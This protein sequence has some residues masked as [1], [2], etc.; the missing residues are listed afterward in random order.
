MSPVVPSHK[1]K[2][3]NP[4]SKADIISPS[5]IRVVRKSNANPT[6]AEGNQAN[7]PRF[8]SKLSSNARDLESDLYE[9]ASNMQ[10][11]LVKNSEGQAEEPK[12]R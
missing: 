4:I 1:I 9:A 3:A 12:A 2:L 7:I 5:D 10:P 8:E 11:L 6:L